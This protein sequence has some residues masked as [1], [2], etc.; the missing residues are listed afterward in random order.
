MKHGSNTDKGK[1]CFLIRVPSVFHPWLLAFS[2]PRRSRK[3]WRFEYRH[4]RTNSRKLL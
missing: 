2:K 4:C 1:K 3:F